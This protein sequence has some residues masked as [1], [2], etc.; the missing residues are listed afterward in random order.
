MTTE[1]KFKKSISIRCDDKMSNML[2]ELE[3]ALLLNT[4]SVMRLALATLYKSRIENGDK[5]DK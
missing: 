4:T 5:D 3:E 2:D 1:S